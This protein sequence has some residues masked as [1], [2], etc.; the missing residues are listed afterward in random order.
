MLTIVSEREG[1]EGRGRAHG[2]FTRWRSVGLAT[3]QFFA[4]L[5]LVALAYVETI[6]RSG[7]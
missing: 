1:L 7:S 3:E 6:S 4:G 2:N 5:S